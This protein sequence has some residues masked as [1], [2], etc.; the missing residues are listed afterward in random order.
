MTNDGGTVGGLSLVGGKISW[1]FY[2]LLSSITNPY[3]WCRMVTLTSREGSGDLR[4]NG[5]CQF[6]EFGCTSWAKLSKPKGTRMYTPVECTGTCN[7][8]GSMKQ[9]IT[10]QLSFLSPIL[11]YNK[12]QLSITIQMNSLGNQIESADFGRSPKLSRLVIRGGSIGHR[13]RVPDASDATSGASRASLLVTPP[14]QRVGGQ[15]L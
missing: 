12:Y 7:Q 14:Q 3:N 13:V 1:F 8:R 11:Y 6:S 2:Q 15:S 4:T 10:K 5:P 9:N